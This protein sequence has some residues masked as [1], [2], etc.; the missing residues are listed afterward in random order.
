MKKLM[1]VKAR[2]AVIP[3]DVG[4][5]EVEK[6]ISVWRERHFQKTFPPGGYVDSIWVPDV[7]EIRPCCRGIHPRWMLTHC[8]SIR[9]V[10]NIFGISLQDMRNGLYPKLH[11]RK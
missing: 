11:K 6:A 9:H 3:V 8:R 5:P 1:A 7:S 10:G 4:T 2:P